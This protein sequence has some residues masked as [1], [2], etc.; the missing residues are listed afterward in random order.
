[1]QPGMY[2]SPPPASTGKVKPSGWWFALAGLIHKM[3]CRGTTSTV[4]RGI[5]RQFIEANARYVKNL[6]V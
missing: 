3:G 2:P 4:S 1:M 5:L 6:D